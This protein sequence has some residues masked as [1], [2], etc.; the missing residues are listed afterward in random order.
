MSSQPEVSQLLSP[1][2][3]STVPFLLFLLVSDVLSLWTLA[4]ASIASSLLMTGVLTILRLELIKTGPKTCLWLSLSL[5]QVWVWCGLHLIFENCTGHLVI[6]TGLMVLAAYIYYSKVV[7]M[8][9]ERVGLMVGNTFLMCVAAEMSM[10]GSSTVI[11]THMET[12]PLAVVI[13]S[14]SK[15][16]STEISN[17]K[18]LLDRLYCGIAILQNDHITYANP[19]LTS[20]GK[21]PKLEAVE[22]KILSSPQLCKA[23]LSFQSN[24]QPYLSFSAPFLDKRQFE[25]EVCRVQ[26]QSPAIALI[27]RE[28]AASPG[29]KT[30]LIRSVTHDLQTPLNCIMHMSEELISAAEM[31][32]GGGQKCEIIRSY[33]H[34]MSFLVNDMVDYSDLA[35]GRKLVLRK[36]RLNLKELLTKCYEMLTFFAEAKHL[37]FQLSLD[38]NLQTQVYTDPSRLTQLVLNLLSNAIKYTFH[39][40]IKL[41]AL[42]KSTSKV[43]VIVEDSGIGID[44]DRLKQ[45]R[46]SEKSL[47]TSGIGLYLAN[48]LAWELGHEELHVSS[49]SGVGSVFSFAVATKEQGSL[50]VTCG[51]EP[52]SPMLDVGEA[53][54]HQMT[55]VFCTSKF[56]QRGVRGADILLVDDYPFNRMVV[57][58]VLEREGLRVDEAENGSIAIQ[59]IQEKAAIAQHYRLILMD[60][61]MPVLDGIRTTERLRAMQRSDPSFLLPPILGHSAFTS[62]ADIEKFLEVGMQAF[63]PKPFIKD[64][65]MS[66]I[67]RFLRLEGKA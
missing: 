30:R 18:P 61:D 2:Q 65:A 40:S 27:C 10:L 60:I 67:W 37:R 6:A 7:E 50:D 21:D 46:R 53:D 66:I 64:L 12:I 59:M 42:Q 28:S 26:L 62:E 45:I 3:L 1:S 19:F 16:K 54:V 25:W 34:F 48:V 49:D 15:H 52:E 8:P 29:F 11:T 43:K 63:I 9:R 20:L 22:A 44:S 36:S 31:P 56:M 5:G 39:G 13:Y 55:P 24:G 47:P 14:L 32:T 51:L 41:I 17:I 38:P 23:L 33:C 4:C 35:A 57:R 58:V